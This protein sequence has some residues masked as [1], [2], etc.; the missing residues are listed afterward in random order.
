MRVA[1]VVR[2]GRENPATRI[3][4]LQLVPALQD[5]G[6]DTRVVPWRPRSRRAVVAGAQQILSSA[7]WADV[8]VLQR[9]N[10]PP[11]LLHALRRINSRIIVDVDDAVWVGGGG[12]AAPNA[13]RRFN[14]AVH[15]ARAVVTGSE[16]LARHARRL[17]SAADVVVARS[18]VDLGRVGPSSRVEDVVPTILWIGTKGNFADFEQPVLRALADVIASGKA[19]FVVISSAPF[20]AV[21]GVEFVAW[22]EAAEERLLARSSI[23]IMPL[24]DDLRSRG[25]CGYKAIQYMAAGLPVVASPVAAACE[26]VQ[27]N[28]TGALAGDEEEW[29]SA[30]ASLVTK[31]ERRAMLGAAGREWVEQN[32]STEVFAGRFLGVIESVA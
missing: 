6:I 30:L 13:E 16:Y 21:P 17:S 25:R 24:R 14:L 11:W 23:G 10:Q 9:P 22:S 12:A 15:S 8:I 3:R 1:L 29:R 28:R 5:A 31:P 7:A 4:M 19:S 27:P 26:L 18:A 20:T 2:D 32:A